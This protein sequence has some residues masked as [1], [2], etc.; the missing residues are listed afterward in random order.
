[1]EE[2]KKWKI[3]YGTVREDP[4]RAEWVDVSTGEV[5]KDT[6]IPSVWDQYES[7]LVDYRNR[8]I[9]Y[10]KDRI[11]RRNNVGDCFC[12]TDWSKY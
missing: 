9:N 4:H 10:H 7:Y 11:I 5:V 1:M 8:V 6:S 2:W 12:S 3:V